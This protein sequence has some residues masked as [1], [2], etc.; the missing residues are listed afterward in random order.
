MQGHATGAD[1]RVCLHPRW[2]VVSVKTRPWRSAAVVASTPKQARF[3]RNNNKSSE[4]HLPR[5]VTRLF[6]RRRNDINVIATICSSQEFVF[7]Q[8]KSQ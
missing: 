1:C 6:R 3:H 4:P 2:K 7:S 8:V 5:Y